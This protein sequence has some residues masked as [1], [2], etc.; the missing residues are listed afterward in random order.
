MIKKI[1]DRC[2]VISSTLMLISNTLMI[3]SAGYHK[4]AYASA[5]LGVVGWIVGW[6]IAKYLSRK[7]REYYEEN[8]LN[9]II[10]FNQRIRAQGDE[11]EKEH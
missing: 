4:T 2:I 5:V 10:E 7:E 6:R 3:Y 1:L 9:P 8:I 11:D